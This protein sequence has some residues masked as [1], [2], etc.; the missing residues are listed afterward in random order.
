MTMTNEHIN[1]HNELRNQYLAKMKEIYE[2]LIAADLAFWTKNMKQ[3]F[4]DYPVLETVAWK[5]GFFYNDENHAF[6]VNSFTINGLDLKEGNSYFS[7]RRWRISDFNGEDIFLLNNQ[8]EE[9]KKIEEELRRNRYLEADKRQELTKELREKYQN[10]LPA[11]Q[12]VAQFLVNTYNTFGE[13]HFA[14]TFGRKANVIFGK[15][16]VLIEDYNDGEAMDYG[17][18]DDLFEDIN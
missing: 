3:I 4:A 18:L 12:V 2:Q 9:D 17:Q 6:A 5:Q 14:D 13:R 16:G 7:P 10:L 8:N 15:E 11:A 1:E